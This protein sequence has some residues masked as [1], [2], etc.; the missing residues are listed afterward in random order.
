MTDEELLAH[1]LPPAMEQYFTKKLPD[2]SP[3]DLRCRIAEFLKGVT[4]LHLSPGDI[5]FSKEID[6]IWHYWILETAEYAILCQRLT[7]GEFIH[8]TSNDYPRATNAQ[9]EEDPKHATRRL[10]VFFCIYVSQFGPIDE[11]R[12]VY[13]P[14]L[15][16]LLKLCGW[17]LAHA[18]DLLL[19]RA[20]DFDAALAAVRPILPLKYSIAGSMAATRDGTDQG[21]KSFPT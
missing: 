9:D 6:A 7:G 5:L 21:G 16:M 17:S 10:I 19:Q 2:V 15:A 18:N 20:R 8:H 11:D 12:L 4:L 3:S 1:Y 13:W 14:P